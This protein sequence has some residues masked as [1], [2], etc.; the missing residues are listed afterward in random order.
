MKE[1]KEFLPAVMLHLPGCPE[2]VVEDALRVAAIEFCETTRVWKEEYVTLAVT[3]AGFQDYAVSN[4]PKD[5]GLCHLHAAWVGEYEVGVGL[6][7]SDQNFYPGQ[8]EDAVLNYRYQNTRN[9]S[10]EI[11]GRA[12]IRINPV[13]NATPKTIVATVSYCPTPVAFGFPDGLYF[14]HHEAIEKKAMYNLMIQVDKPWSNPQMA[15]VNL[16][17]FDYLKDAAA[18]ANGPVRRTPLRVSPI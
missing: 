4:N 18:N 3:A 2:L 10:I 14:K 5:A 13:P 7:G 6:P 17:R 11:V 16:A 1:W 9:Y 8:T 12:T 15:M